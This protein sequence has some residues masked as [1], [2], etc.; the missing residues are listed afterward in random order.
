[1]KGFSLVEVLMALFILSI[2]MLGLLSLQ[3]IAIRRNYDAYLSSVAATRIAAAD[4]NASV[5]QQDNAAL[6]PQGIGHKNGT[7]ISICWF[8]R[9]T[10]KQKCLTNN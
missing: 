7:A 6:L 10:H 8:S 5:W 1:M 2:G 4:Q 3:T 9:L